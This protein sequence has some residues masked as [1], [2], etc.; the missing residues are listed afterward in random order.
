M[1]KLLKKVT[2]DSSLL[3]PPVAKLYHHRNQLLD[4]VN[5]LENDKTALQNSVSNLQNHQSMLEQKIAELKQYERDSFPGTRDIFKETF[6][7]WIKIGVIGWCTNRNIEIIDQCVASL[8]A[9]AIVEIGSYCG[10]SMS[11]I[12]HSMRMHKKTNYFYS[13]D[14]WYYEGYHPGD[15]ISGAFTTDEW[16]QHTEDMFK[17]TE[18]LAAKHVPHSH[19]K[20]NSNDFFE[21]WTNNASLIDL[22]GNSTQLGGDIAFAYIDGDHSYEQS[23]RDF[24]N[25]D[26]F[27]VP[28][29]YVFFDDSTENVGF[30]CKIT[31]KEVMNMPNYELVFQP[32][33]GN[34]NKCFR[35]KY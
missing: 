25:V 19:I 31:A 11:I 17:L 21:Y 27:L 4:I 3:I 2:R 23:K 34:S 32:A 16:R 22:H 8:P 26:K 6:V 35:K 12:A 29:G 20:K 13:V 15:V 5:N 14:D 18:K 7:D 9:G 33:D 30:G 28:G 1:L 10:L 24:I